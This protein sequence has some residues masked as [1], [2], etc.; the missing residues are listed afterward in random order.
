MLQALNTGHDG[1]LSTVHASGPGPAL[2][3]LETLALLAGV[4]LSL[5]AVRAQLAMSIDAI[6][7][8]ARDRS[9]AR[10]V[11]SV[12]EVVDGGDHAV[13]VRM[14]HERRGGRLCEVAAPTRPAR[15]A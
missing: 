8:V 1:S 6:V 14:L 2:R 5:A 11:E 15:A 4:G 13:G 10:R 12:A 3:R 7:H 9:G